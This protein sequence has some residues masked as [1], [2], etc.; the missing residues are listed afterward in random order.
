MA[1]PVYLMA[2]PK[3]ILSLS[4]PTNGYCSMGSAKKAAI[5]DAGR[6]MMVT[7]VK[8]VI[9]L[10]EVRVM[11]ASKTFDCF[12]FKSRRSSSCNNNRSNAS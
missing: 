8:T 7:I 11:R 2:Y 1:L 5:N 12:C 9:V 3:S 10:P 6:K 4:L